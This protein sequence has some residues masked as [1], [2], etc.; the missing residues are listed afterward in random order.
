MTEI[1]VSIIGI[2]DTSQITISSGS[3]V[4]DVLRKLGLN[5]SAQIVLR[6]KTPIPIDE[7]VMENDELRVIETFSGG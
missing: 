2:G 1:E 7:I 4:E 3:T 5:V 6:G